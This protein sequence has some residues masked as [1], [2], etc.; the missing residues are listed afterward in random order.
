MYIVNKINDKKDSL[1]N[2]KMVNIIKNSI[3]VEMKKQFFATFS[4]AFKS[5]LEINHDKNKVLLLNI[6]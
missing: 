3:F 2:A 6:D 1:T 5:Y 4:C